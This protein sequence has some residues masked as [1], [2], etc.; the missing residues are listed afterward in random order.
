MFPFAIS[1]KVRCGEDRADQCN[2][3]NSGPGELR[4]IVLR[5]AADGDAR[6]VDCPTDV[7]QGLMKLPEIRTAD[8]CT[9][10]C[11]TQF[12]GCYKFHRLGNLHRAF[13]TFDPQ[14]YGFHVCSH[15]LLLLSL[16]CRSCID[17]VF[18]VR[19]E[20]TFQLLFGICL[21]FSGCGNLLHHGST[22]CIGIKPGIQSVL[23]GADILSCNL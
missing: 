22:L 13:D 23:I 16:F 20:R 5:D 10:L 18:G 21:E 12:G 17:K 9:F 2:A 4:Q 19:F 11:F 7:L 15:R 8:F 3:V 14:L 1:C 6:D